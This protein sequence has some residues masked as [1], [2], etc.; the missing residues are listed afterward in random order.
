[1]KKVRIYL[2]SLN[3]P[4]DSEKIEKQ[5]GNN[6]SHQLLLFDSNR[7]GAVNNLV[8]VVPSGALIIWKRDRCSGIRKITKIEAKGGKEEKFWKKLRRRFICEGFTIRAPYVEERTR[9]PY[10][11][12]YLPSGEKTK[13]VLIDP[14]ID[15][16]PPP[17]R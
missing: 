16:D 11:I 3:I 12:E 9:F 5:S 17:G 7:N 1:M 4:V 10:N 14:Y 15:V 13:P 6:K 2:R 8:T